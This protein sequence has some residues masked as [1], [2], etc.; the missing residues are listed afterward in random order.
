MWLTKER[1]SPGPVFGSTDRFEG[2]AIFFDTYK[3]SRPGTTFPLVMAMMGDGKTAYD[4]EH[5][6]KA[7][8]LASCSVRFPLLRDRLFSSAK[9]YPRPVGSAAPPFPPKPA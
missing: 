5:D 1:A 7:N 4:Q 6:G 9:K 3:N 2:L 8:E